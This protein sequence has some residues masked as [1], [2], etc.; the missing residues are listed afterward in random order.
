MTDLA[1]WLAGHVS[2][3]IY[4]TLSAAG[5]QYILE[6]SESKV[7][8]LGKLDDFAK[9]RSGVT[10]SIHKISFPLYG[11]HEGVL[12]NDLLDQV[13]CCRE[14]TTRSEQP[15]LHH[16]F[17]RNNRFSKRHHAYL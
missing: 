3:P 8:F 15:G 14:Y 4:P 9:Q 13:S 12:W 7:I 16:V 10:E 5:I 1:I 6:H 17:V 2:V 11:P